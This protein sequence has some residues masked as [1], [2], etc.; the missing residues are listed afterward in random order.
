MDSAIMSDDGWRLFFAVAAAW[1]LAAALPALV[2]PRRAFRLLY[3][4]E[5]DR[6][7]ELF[8]HRMIGAVVLLFGIGYGIIALEPSA[9]LGLVLLGFLAKVVVVVA[10]AALVVR[11]R[12]TKAA[13]LIAAVDALFAAFFLRYLATS[14][15]FVSTLVG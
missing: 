1:N 8:Q 15:F 3:G 12:A 2:T 5:S 14:V 11:R 9:N 6:F 7:Y 13:L 10:F 4:V